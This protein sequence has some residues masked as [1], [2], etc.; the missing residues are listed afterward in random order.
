MNEVKQKDNFWLY[1]VGGVILFIGV[2]FMIK[3]SEHDKYTKAKQL[4][5]EDINNSAY[6]IKK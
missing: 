4:V 2:V 3:G 5:A 1:V 6:A